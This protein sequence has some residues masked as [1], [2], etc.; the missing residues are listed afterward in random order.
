MGTY[1]ANGS[2]FSFGGTVSG[3]RRITA[4]DDGNVIDVTSLDDLNQI[5]EDGVGA[6]EISVELLGSSSID[7][8][9]KSTATIS[10][11]DGGNFSITNA[12]CSRKETDAS[13][14]GALTTTLTFVP[15]LGS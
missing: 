1:I 13:T 3:L 12:L 8:G 14:G 5:Y 4:S 2:T 6:L 11:A 9:D 10:F 15:G 7:R